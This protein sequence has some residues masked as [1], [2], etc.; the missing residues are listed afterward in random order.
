M[1]SPDMPQCLTGCAHT[2]KEARE[3][4]K[5][6]EKGRNEDENSTKS[7][8]ERKPRSFCLSNL[9]PALP[10][11]LEG[12]FRQFQSNDYEKYLETLGV[13]P[14]I[15]S[16]VIR[17]NMVLKINQEID[18]RWKFVYETSIKAKSMRGFSTNT[19]KL[20]ENKFV[21]GEATAELL[22]DWDQRLVESVLESYEEM[23]TPSKTCCQISCPAVCEEHHR[24]LVLIQ[25]AR[26]DQKITHDSTIVYELDKEDPDVMVVTSRVGG[27]LE[28]VVAIRRFRRQ[29]EQENERRI[30]VI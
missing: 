22:D 12:T 16:M 11:P 25:T 6:K 15:I 29:R 10:D 4:Q 14:M 18:K 1:T 28:D 9:R 3:V 20:V 8:R 17:A 23:E 7:R 2:Y 24:R 13:G 21:V 30:S 5:E 19:P 27:E 26:T